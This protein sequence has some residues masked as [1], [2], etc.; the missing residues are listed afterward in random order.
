MR[1][2]ENQRAVLEALARYLR[3]GWGALCGRDMLVFGFDPF[4]HGP[5]SEPDFRRRAADVLEGLADNNLVED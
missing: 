4:R 5:I 3:A 1:T 2:T